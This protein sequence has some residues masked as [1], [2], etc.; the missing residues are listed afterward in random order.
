MVGGESLVKTKYSRIRH[1]SSLARRT[2]FLWALS[3]RRPNNNRDSQ[4]HSSRSHLLGVG[5][6]LH[7]QEGGGG[8][9][10]R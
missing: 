5:R 6:D 10:H 9:V 2:Q 4:I 3:A 1:A 7:V 8:Q